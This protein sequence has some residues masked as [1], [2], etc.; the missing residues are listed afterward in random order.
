MFGRRDRKILAA[1]RTNQIA[2][3]DTFSEVMYYFE[4]GVRVQ[5]QLLY[6]QSRNFTV[7][8]IKKCP[9]YPKI[10]HLAVVKLL[11]LRDGIRSV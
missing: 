10:R 8:Q 5:L 11:T 4:Y 3:F 7:E 1:R 2:G 6:I 9:S